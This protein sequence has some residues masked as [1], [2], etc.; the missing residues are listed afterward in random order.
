MGMR[1]FGTSGATRLAL[2]LFV[3][4]GACGAFGQVN[5]RSMP[6]EFVKVNTVLESRP[7]KMVAPAGQVNTW[8]FFP[9]VDIRINQRAFSKPHPKPRHR[10][11][12]GIRGGTPA[13]SIGGTS[14]AVPESYF[15]GISFT[16]AIPPDPHMAVGPNHVVQVVNSRIAF[17]DKNSGSQLFG[18]ESTQFFSGTG[19]LDFQFDPRVFYDQFNERWIL[20]F[21]TT[22]FTSQ[23]QML[24]AVSDDENPLGLWSR[25]VYNVAFD[26]G[27]G[28]TALFDYP[29]VGMT[30]DAI[31]VGGNMFG[32]EG[33][34][35][36]AVTV[37]RTAPLYNNQGV[38]A[39]EFI[40][41]GVTQGYS[42]QPGDT[43]TQNTTMY[44]INVAPPNAVRLF[45]FTGVDTATP[46]VTITTVPVQTFLE[47][48]N[49]PSGGSGTGLD[50]I[51]DRIMDSVARDNFFLAAHTVVL[52]G[53]SESSVRWYEF[54]MGT[55]PTAGLPTLAQ[56]GN[57]TLDP[58]Q[59]ALM[60]AITKNAFGDITVIYT[61]SSTSIFSD[62]VVSSRVISDSPGSI[63]AP[64][65]LRSGLAPNEGGF[66]GRWGDYFSAVVDAADDATFWG[67]GEVTRADGFWETEIQS[68]VVTTG[69]PGGGGVDYDTISISA[70]MG[71]YNAGGLADVSN[72]DNNFFDVDSTL[73]TGQGHF[74][75]VQAD[76]LI[77]EP[78][79]N[80]TQLNFTIEA[81]VDPGVNATGIVFLW[82]WNTNQWEYGKAFALAKL[83]NDQQGTKI[84]QNPGRF[85]SPTG[86]V[87]MVFRAHDT[88]RRRGTT[89]SPFR[90]RTDL[91]KLNVKT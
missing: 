19:A 26:I 36:A 40:F 42:I 86:Q 68:W 73:L 35:A 13:G 79:A 89:P 25:F 66:R 54:D 29:Q 47:A 39:S 62:L 12:F 2:T 22:D 87:R 8:D 59:W 65:L 60:P 16:G 90:L 48:D 6:P 82:N 70:F 23:S 71:V 83:G 33:G 55:W 1:I 49:A 51:S 84:K 30:Q 74:G 46:V 63:G 34:F 14:R 9:Q 28:E 76:F 58:G 44:A 53:D 72:S 38:Q 11:D 21:L 67:N 56:E 31:A 50:T 75:A 17:F 43:Y 7:G 64:T 69:G 27:D 88:Y 52:Q 20:L 3:V 24:L 10:L 61:R 85:V 81:N 80:V 4:G 78:S 37:I 57:I 15:G 77:A 18:Q 32:F 45:A 41:P 91:V 5:I